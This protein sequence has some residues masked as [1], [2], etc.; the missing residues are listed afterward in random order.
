[1]L[2]YSIIGLSG[3]THAGQLIPMELIIKFKKYSYGIYK[4]ENSSMYLTSG[5]RWWG[6]RMRF[7]SNCEIVKA[8]LEKQ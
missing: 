4:N 5:A 2:G 3:H 6:P 7:F 8:V 1:M